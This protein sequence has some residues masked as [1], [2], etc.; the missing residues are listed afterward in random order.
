[1]P[2]CAREGSRR[3]RRRRCALKNELGAADSRSARLARA[4]PGAPA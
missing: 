1:V 2:R 4:R 3:S